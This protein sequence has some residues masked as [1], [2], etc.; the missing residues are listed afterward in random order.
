MTPI[1]LDQLKDVVKVRALARA[2]GLN[3]RTVWS[4]I[5]QNLDFSDEESV[6]LD[7]ALAE[8]FAKAELVVTRALTLDPPRAKP[9]AE[10]AREYAAEARRQRDK[11]LHDEASSS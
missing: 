11:D 8:A 3:D 10:L 4:K 6:A 7:R 9:M 1:Q 5:Q 2:A